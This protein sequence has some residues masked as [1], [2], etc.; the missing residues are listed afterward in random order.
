[1]TELTVGRLIDIL[2]NA[3]PAMPVSVHVAGHTSDCNLPLRVG[4]LRQEWLQGDPR[5]LCI[6]DFQDREPNIDESIVE[7]LD[8]GRPLPKS[9]YEGLDDRF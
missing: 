1:M 4:I 2:A 6:G 9:I 5:S 8:G 7:L 3:D